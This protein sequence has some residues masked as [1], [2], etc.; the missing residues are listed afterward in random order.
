MYFLNSYLFFPVTS[1]NYFIHYCIVN[2]HV[3]CEYDMIYH[4]VP[5]IFKN[6][7]SLD[8]FSHDGRE[9]L[10]Y[11]TASLYIYHFSTVPDFSS[12][13]YSGSTGH[14]NSWYQ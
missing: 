12:E 8:F 9:Q 4:D 11:F 10:N 2:K 7:F 1:S 13:K 14:K 6:K 3:M 5:K